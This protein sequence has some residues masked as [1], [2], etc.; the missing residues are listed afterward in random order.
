MTTTDTEAAFW[1]SIEA[2][3][4]DALPKLILADFLDER[5]RDAEAD[6]WRWIAETGRVPE[7]GTQTRTRRIEHRLTPPSSRYEYVEKTLSRWFWEPAPHDGPLN[8]LSR[9]FPNFL[10]RHLF[11]FYGSPRCYFRRV[12]H[13]SACDAYEALCLIWSNCRLNGTD[14]LTG[15]RLPAGAGTP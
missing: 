2:A 7:K 14:P 13:K 15:A 12:G 11:R 3:P 1:S 9:H 10:P 8:G 4:G 6:C 5:G